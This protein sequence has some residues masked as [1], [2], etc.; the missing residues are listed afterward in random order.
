MT[1]HIGRKSV[2]QNK[3]L[4]FCEYVMLHP[5]GARNEENIMPS[6]VGA[7]DKNTL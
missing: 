7:I 4:K 5:C 6:A 2:R 3:K 1:V